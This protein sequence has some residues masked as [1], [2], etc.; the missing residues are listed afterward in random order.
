MARDEFPRP[1]GLLRSLLKAICLFGLG[2]AWAFAAEPAP[3]TGAGSMQPGEVVRDGTRLSYLLGGSGDSTLVFVH[4]MPNSASQWRCQ[5]PAFQ[6]SHRILAVDLLGYGHSDKIGSIPGS[7]TSL[8]ADDVVY[9]ME[10]V[11]VSKVT[12]VGHAIGGHVA[13]DI[14]SRYP[15]LVDRLVLVAT[16]PQFSQT[17]DWEYGFTEQGLQEYRDDLADNPDGTLATMFDSSVAE[18]CEPQRDRL[19]GYLAGQATQAGASTVQ[20]FFD[21]VALEDLRE[22]LG[23]IAAPTLIISGQLDPAVPEGVSLYMREHIPDALLVELPE[24]GHFLNFTRPA[25]FNA[26]LAAFLSTDSCETCEALP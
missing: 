13:I 6:D 26:L 22:S 10:Q 2:G 4:A 1:A 5:F 25:L 3:G 18:V 20:G 15:Q 14:A 19:E 11:G 8:F 21:H 9:V 16:S 7:L 24:T 23:K 17:D 12:L